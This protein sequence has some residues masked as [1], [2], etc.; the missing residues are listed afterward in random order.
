MKR[1]SPSELKQFTQEMKLASAPKAKK[2]EVTMLDALKFVQAGVAKKDFVPA[3]QHYRIRG[4]RIKTFNG[5]LGLSCPIAVDLDV[6]P[7]A[8]PF[9]AA[10]AAC[11]DTVEMHVHKNGKLVIKSGDFKTSV[12]CY[13]LEGFPEIEPSGR[14]IQL[15]DRLLP[16]LKFLSPFVAED[17]SRPWACGILFDGECA[18][19]TNNVVLQQYWLGFEFP[20]RVNLPI[21]A[22][23][24]LIR[25]GEDPISMQVTDT[26]VVF[27]F[28]GGRW[29]SSQLFETKW[30]DIALYLD[31]EPTATPTPFPAGFFEVLERIAPFTDPLGR[32]YLLGDRIA[33]TPEPDDAGTSIEL[34]GVPSKGVYNVHQL[35]NLQK[36]VS[37]IDWESY[38]KPSLFFGEI[39]RGLIC[40][41][42]S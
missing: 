2:E 22:V 38:P 32:V 17:A 41:L 1:S 13:E 5:T 20:H 34:A 42:N 10:I 30:P 3:L 21:S 4:G 40:G 37:T 36:I 23:N 11:I 35:L 7:R 18:Y 6:A 28:N 14:L 39:A 31:T 19:A 8:E 25:I 27:H 33:T 29:V 24:T 9:L 16:A 15:T 26:R 12:E